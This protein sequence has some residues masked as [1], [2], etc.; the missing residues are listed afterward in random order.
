M[1]CHTVN[2]PFRALK[3]GYPTEVE[4]LLPLTNTDTYPLKSTIRFQFP[5]R[6]GLPPVT[7]WW[8]DGG[9]LLPDPHNWHIQDCS[10]KPPAD[11]TADVKRLLDTVPD[12]GCLLI[13]DKGKIFAPD[14]Y[15]TR[16]FLKLSDEPEFVNGKDHP[17]VLA[18]PQT[19]P[20]NPFQGDSDFRHHQ[21]WIAECKGGPKSY[22]TFDVAA[23]LTEIIL[24][25]CVSLRVGKKIEWDGPN[26][27]A[28]NTPEAAQ[29]IRRHNRKGWPA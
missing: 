18:I 16:F 3:L 1:A 20:R 21:E 8:Y 11:V 17:A 24:L 27:K 5:E 13:G 14:D 4:A 23:Y 10:N 9:N 7:F 12:S 26:M 28:L 2:M 25:G 22:S 6:N 19:I 29:Y 15:G